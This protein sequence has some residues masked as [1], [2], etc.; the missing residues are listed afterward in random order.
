MKSLFKESKE[1]NNIELIDGLY[2]EGLLTRHYR[3]IALEHAGLERTWGVWTSRLLL[4]FGLAFILSGIVFFFAFNWNKMPYFVKFSL[5]QFG[6]ISST[7]LSLYF[8]KNNFLTT[9]CVMIASV[10]IGVFLAVFGQCYQTGASSF[11]LFLGWSVCLLPWA[12]LYN[13]TPLWCLFFITTELSIYL[14]WVQTSE[15]NS[16]TLSTTCA[17]LALFNASIYLARELLLGSSISFIKDSGMRYVTVTFSLLFS[18]LPIIEN[19]FDHYSNQ[20]ANILSILIHGILCCSLFA[21]H[22][23]YKPDHI[24]IALLVVNTCVIIESFVVRIFFLEKN[25]FYHATGSLFAS[26][27]TLCLFYLAYLFYRHIV[28]SMR[29]STHDL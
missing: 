5:I 4:W 9:L 17:I 28:K 15:Y 19:I 6:L 14:W 18:S 16:A 29:S 12:F 23:I 13:K 22:W 8:Y 21:Y 2:K 24:V 25:I 20:H 3:N 10:L 11:T 1:Q 27:A 26:I 7:A